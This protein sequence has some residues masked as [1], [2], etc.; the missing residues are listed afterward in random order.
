MLFGL[1][2]LAVPVII[3]L[4]NR[5]KARQMDW[6]AM[7][8]LL[9][10]VVARRRRLILEEVLLLIVR[11]LA[12]AL[13]VVAMARPFLPSS[14]I[15]PSALVLPAILIAAVL[16]AVA[17]AFW[18]REDTRR[19][20]LRALAALLIIAV[21]ASFLERWL[22]HRRWFTGGDSRDT[23]ILLD[24][25]TSMMAKSGDKTNFEL[26]IEEARIVADMNRPGDSI[27]LYV[28]GPVPRAI[29]RAPTAD[30]QEIAKALDDPSL[31]PVGGSLGVIEALNAAAS[32]LAEGHSPAKRIVLITDG[33][34]AGWDV[35]G[36][37]RWKFIT[38]S[39]KNL[40]SPPQFICRKLPLPQAFRNVAVSDITF[41]R[42]VIG[43]DRPVKIDAKIS[44]SG[45]LPLQP[46]AAELLVDG[47]SVTR[48]DFVKEIP[49]GSAETLRF[50]YRFET[51]G[52]HIV[53]ARVISE[54]DLVAD[55]AN[56][57]VVN[58]EDKLPVL[59]VDGAPAERFFQGAAAFMRVALT[60]REDP[61]PDAKPDNAPSPAFSPFLVE[62]KVEGHGPG[63]HRRPE[64][65]P[66]D[67][68]GQRRTPARPRHRPPG[69]VRA[70]RRRPADRPGPA[71][72]SGVLQPLAHGRRPAA[73]AGDAH[74]A[75]YPQGEPGS[76]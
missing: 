44:N 10:S 13:I 19:K 67:H 47:I 12:I 48:E 21:T 2:A 74:R 11:C 8:F 35:Q 41:S 60:P 20:I 3:H 6:G 69:G 31:K 66:R 52:R 40:P 28:A 51:P 4:L 70:K 39:F 46:S 49:P 53:T 57:R 5:A 36:E 29:I 37:G 34:E 54:D 76:F 43:M 15:V 38:D 64:R 27:A 30:R 24:G 45:T 33:Q 1:A 72:R 65:L 7:R 22:Q 42:P 58:V 16:A 23:V 18:N 75:H 26:A 61:A 9:A 62:P 14:S 59:L 50:E 68:P 55:N 56:D 63:E 73:P 25:S 71:R 32:S 17:A